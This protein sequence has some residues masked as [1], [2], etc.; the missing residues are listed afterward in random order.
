MVYDAVRSDGE[1]KL[2]PTHART[3]ITRGK[4][5]IIRCRSV[6]A[7]RSTNPKGACQAVFHR[8]ARV[9]KVQIT[10]ILDGG[11]H[12]AFEFHK[13]FNRWIS[14]HDELVDLTEI[15]QNTREVRRLIVRR[16]VDRVRAVLLYH[17]IMTLFRLLDIRH[18]LHR[19][20]D[21]YRCL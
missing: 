11:L 21:L 18:R 19:E 7:S 2:Y 8:R 20:R 17:Q 13:V 10:R 14:A 1:A 15:R 5:I 12:G 4:W 9:P 6:R 16:S 3:V